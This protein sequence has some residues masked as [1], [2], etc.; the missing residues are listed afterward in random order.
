MI[1]WAIKRIWV[2]SLL[3]EKV[4]YHE[5]DMTL[6]KKELKIWSYRLAIMLLYSCLE[7]NS[8]FLMKAF[9]RLCISCTKRPL[10]CSFVFSSFISAVRSTANA[11]LPSSPHFR[12]VSF[13]FFSQNSRMSAFRSQTLFSTAKVAAK[14]TRSHAPPRPSFDL[15]CCVSCVT[16]ETSS[17]TWLACCTVATG[18]M[19]FFFLQCCNVCQRHAL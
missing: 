12:A 5:T 3:H 15:F 16:E 7:R 18:E 9:T 6:K 8:N 4:K 10:T 17:G 2:S 13:P 14:I 19:I 11:N 1:E